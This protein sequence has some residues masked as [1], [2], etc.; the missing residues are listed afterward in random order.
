MLLNLCKRSRN[1]VRT[2]EFGGKSFSYDSASQVCVLR[3]TEPERLVTDLVAALKQRIESMYMQRIKLPLADSVIRG[4]ET[5]RWCLA[6]QPPILFNRRQLGDIAVRV[7]ALIDAMLG[8]G[9]KPKDLDATQSSSSPSLP[10]PSKCSSPIKFII[11]G[12]PGDGKTLSAAVLSL[13]LQDHVKNSKM[14]ASIIIPVFSSSSS[15]HPHACDVLKAINHQL[16]ERLPNSFRRPQPPHSSLRSHAH[17]FSYYTTT[18]LGLFR[19]SIIVIVI[20]DAHLISHSVACVEQPTYGYFLPSDLDNRV[21]TIVTCDPLH[22]AWLQ[23]QSLAPPSSCII[24]LKEGACSVD[25]RVEIISAFASRQLKQMSE[26]EGLVMQAM[27]APEARAEFIRDVHHFRSVFATAADNFAQFCTMQER[28]AAA[29]PLDFQASF[30]R[31]IASAQFA[32]WFESE[33]GLR[34]AGSDNALFFSHASMA[35]LR[36]SC[37]A[38]ESLTP[39]ADVRTATIVK[40]ML[41]AGLADV[42]LT[43]TVSLGNCVLAV[44][45]TACQRVSKYI[46]ARVSAL[47]SCAPL[48]LQELGDVLTLDGGAVGE[49]DA[50]VSAYSI[51]QF[52]L[53]VV[54]DVLVYLAVLGV[55]RMVDD[56]GGAVVVPP[57]LQPLL[58]QWAASKGFGELDAHTAIGTLFELFVLLALYCP[59]H[60]FFV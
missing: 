37:A 12:H 16:R 28:S 9:G 3:Q 47:V 51:K 48:S 1:S 46:V 44:L 38:L 45:D 11:T 13:F 27:A 39:T 26:A 42:C 23:S 36:G 32:K 52:P 19:D 18:L 4:I 57:H 50:S 53:R 58:L 22:V 17:A 56:T 20:D 7:I 33:D 25:C 10:S 35:Y 55:A 60:H 5:W 49:L 41:D 14:T 59:C 54:S 21:I 30:K 24:G 43:E 34:S 2:S 15:C 29:M 6:L 8:A 31:V 40:R